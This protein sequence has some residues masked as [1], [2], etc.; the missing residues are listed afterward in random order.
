MCLC[1][2]LVVVFV[3]VF[4]FV[5]VCVFV[6]VCVCLCVCVCVCLCVCACVCLPK[7]STNHGKCLPNQSKIDQKTIKI[8]ARGDLGRLLGVR[9]SSKS[10]KKGRDGQ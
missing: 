5:F 9:S 10:I 7:S 1:V 6:C 2:E 3:F 8:E 4:V